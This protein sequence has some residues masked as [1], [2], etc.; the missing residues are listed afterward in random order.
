MSNEPH[1]WLPM[2]SGISLDQH[3]FAVDVLKQLDCETTAPSAIVDI[4]NIE[5][6]TCA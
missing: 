6:H 4:S 3:S 1:P 2:P 5:V